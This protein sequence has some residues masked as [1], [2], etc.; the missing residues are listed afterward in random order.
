MVPLRVPSLV[1]VLP[2]RPVEE[3]REPGATVGKKKGP[4]AA[5]E[6]RKDS[7][8]FQTV[9]VDSVRADS[10]VRQAAPS[11]KVDSSALQRTRPVLPDVD[12]YN[13]PTT[14]A[15]GMKKHK[16]VK[17]ITED[18]YKISAGKDSAKKKTN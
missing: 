2:W 13:T 5:V 18:D 4:V 14:P 9:P 8:S 12:L 7:A 16:G 3:S 1:R 15:P 6:T 11:P 17:G 10:V